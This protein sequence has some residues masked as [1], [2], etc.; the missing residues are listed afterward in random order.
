MLD[1]NGQ[2][3]SSPVRVTHFG[4]DGSP[5]HEATNPQLEYDTR[6][7]N[8]L[9][10]FRGHKT[11]KPR[12]ARRREAIYARMLDA[13]GRP[14][15]TGAVRLSRGALGYEVYGAPSIAF[16]PTARSFLVVW[17]RRAGSEARVVGAGGG[18]R[19]RVRRLSRRAGTPAVAANPRSRSFL[20]L[21]TG[22]RERV[23]GARL[24]GDGDP[25]VR[26]FRVP[27]GHVRAGPRGARRTIDEFALAYDRR[28]GRF[29]LAWTL[30]MDAG[31]AETDDRIAGQL[32]SGDGRRRL[33]PARDISGAADFD[34][35]HASPKIAY[36]A[37]D[38]TF[39]VVWVQWFTIS[40][41]PIPC[42]DLHEVQFARLT[43]SWRRARAG[44]LSRPDD[45]PGRTVD[46]RH[47]PCPSYAGDPV[48]SERP[49]R[50][51]FLA[52]WHRFPFVLGVAR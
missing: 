23:F 40:S 51:G 2:P 14:R 4:K 49:G 46:P 48:V 38:D 9:L 19:G 37:E 45:P 15:G 17:G 35:F 22:R 20:V 5:R 43:S 11:L 24:D 6:T 27:I 1:P 39:T 7:G 34:G 26:R 18:P 29:A 32:L 50:R 16:E 8:F 36:S 13:A 3:A 25:L 47:V 41:A 12:G 30:S 21:W 31:Y 28:S 10:A 42:S 44:T 52:V 33:S